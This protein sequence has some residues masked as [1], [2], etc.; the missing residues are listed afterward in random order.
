MH[1]H[2]A[3]LFLVVA[4]FLMVPCVKSV[5]IRNFSWSSFSRI[6]TEYRDL[7]GKSLYSVRIREKKKQTRKNSVYGYF[8]HSGKS[9]TPYDIRVLTVQIVESIG[10]NENINQTIFK[11]KE[12]YRF[13]SL[14]F[15]KNTP[16]SI[17]NYNY[18][19]LYNLVLIPVITMFYFVGMVKICGKI[20]FFSNWKVHKSATIW[21]D[22]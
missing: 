12:K 8:S 18:I 19:N 11:S 4:L 17:Q 1:H 10:E 21:A 15:S 9:F 5:Q 14:I 2:Q 7:R 22:Y 13:Y 3:T 16:I 20:V 6:Q